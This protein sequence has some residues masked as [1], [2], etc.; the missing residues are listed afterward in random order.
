[1]DD[2]TAT[3]DYETDQYALRYRVAYWFI[4]YASVYAAAEYTF[5]TDEQYGDWDRYRL[6]I[7]CLFRY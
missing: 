6:S 1:M 7:G 2:E 5:E 3:K 4:R